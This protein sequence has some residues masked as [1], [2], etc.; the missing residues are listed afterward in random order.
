MRISVRLFARYRELAGAPAVE[1][2]VPAGAT[3]GQVWGRVQESI[4]ALRGEAHPLLACDREYARADR[5]LAGGEE[6][7]AFPPVSGG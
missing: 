5:I 4:P 7:A 2:E 3:L 6:I 1:M